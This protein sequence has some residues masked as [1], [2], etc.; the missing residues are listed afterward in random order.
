M[1]SKLYCLVEKDW[2]PDG[3]QCDFKEGKDATGEKGNDEVAIGT[4]DTSTLCFRN[5][6]EYSKKNSNETINGATWHTNEKRCFGEIGAKYLANTHRGWKSCIFSG[7]K[8]RTVWC[9]NIFIFYGQ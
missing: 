3:V 6:L 5:V 9:D 4:A 7:I 1:I 8:K 2:N